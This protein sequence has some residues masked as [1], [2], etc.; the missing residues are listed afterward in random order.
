MSLES[1]PSNR[2]EPRQF[3]HN[4]T[5]NPIAV[6]PWTF[7]KS[8]ILQSCALGKTHRKKKHKSAYLSHGLHL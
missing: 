1:N 8:H 6:G 3:Q 4:L 7:M 2:T 5:G